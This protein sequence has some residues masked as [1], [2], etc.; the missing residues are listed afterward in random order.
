MKDAREECKF[1]EEAKGT[2][3]GNDVGKCNRQHDG[4]TAILF[5]SC[6]I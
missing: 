5:L 4:V 3:K 6:L 1:T 2:S